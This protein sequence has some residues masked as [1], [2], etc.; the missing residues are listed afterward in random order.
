MDLIW[1]KLEKSC[2]KEYFN[3]A[4]L[5]VTASK[6]ACFDLQFRRQ[7]QSNHLGKTLPPTVRAVTEVHIFVVAP[8]KA[9]YKIIGGE[10]K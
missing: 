10:C 6:E 9:G 2:K 8:A 3:T 5:C 7:S 4:I 1:Y